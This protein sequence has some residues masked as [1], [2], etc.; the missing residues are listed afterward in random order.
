MGRREEAVAAGFNAFLAELR[1]GKAEARSRV[2]LAM[3]DLSAP[4]PIT[5][6]KADNVPLEEVTEITA[7]D[8]RP[9]GMTPLNDAVA[10]TVRRHEKRVGEGDRAIVVVLTDGYENCSRMTS[11]TLRKLIIAKERE[12]WEF[13]Y[14]GETRTPGLNRRRSRWLPPGNHSTSTRMTPASLTRWPFPP[15]V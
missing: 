12:G 10:K 5:R 6:V 7:A 9:R 11:S 15:P 4:E 2:T 3:F 8:Y 14:L 13:I 1:D